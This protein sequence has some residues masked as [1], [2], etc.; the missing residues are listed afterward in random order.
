MRILHVTTFL[1]GGAGRMITALALAQRQ[2]GHDVRVA[3]DAGGEPGYGT[4]PEYR[5]ALGAGDVR[6]LPL[7]STFT[8]DLAANTE[9]AQVLRGTLASWPAD[10]V[11]T[12]AAI[13]SLVARLALGR[14]PAPLIQTM[15]GWGIAKN[16][17]QAR[18]D[19]ALLNLVDAVVTP[20]VAAS[21]TLQ[22][23][24]VVAAPMTVI[25][26]G[27]PD[28]WMS[29][30]DRPAIRASDQA[31]FADLAR[32]GAAVALCIGT[33]GDRKNQRLLI[34]AL[35][36]PPLSAVHAVFI[37]D[38]DVAPLQA[39]AQRLGVADRS[40]VLGYRDDASRYL[41]QAR[42]VVLPSRNEG[43][44]LT[45]LE[46]LRDAVPVVASRIP[47]IAEAIEDR[48]TGHLFDE[49]SVEALARAL[50][51]ALAASP[52]EVEAMRQRMRQ[53]FASRYTLSGMLAGYAR[54]YASVLDGA[55]MCERGC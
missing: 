20:S 18:T 47:E 25:P 35:V 52:E 30:E 53:A 7:T 29:R 12:H 22:R 38:G 42:V 5:E 49:G 32:R 54:L 41:A 14:H 1:Q 36:S 34:E 19:V 40:H 28:R 16:P 11:H 3:L 15:H 33:I 21:G 13:P 39:E 45:V 43:L 37:G 27:L 44:P 6:L 23:L 51:D 8:R 50:S 24:G 48:R 2:A 31:L 4:Y 17:A 10:V 55:Q 26:Y 46:A 9:A